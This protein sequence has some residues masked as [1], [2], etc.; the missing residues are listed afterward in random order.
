MY[1][2]KTISG[3]MLGMCCILCMTIGLLDGSLEDKTPDKKFR[4]VYSPIF[5]TVF[6]H[7][8][9]VNGFLILVVD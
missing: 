5:W 3:I 1:A 6:R 9:F 7:M 8:V 4:G 2:K